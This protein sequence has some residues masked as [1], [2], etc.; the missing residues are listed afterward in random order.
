MS[1]PVTWQVILKNTTILSDC[2][3]WHHNLYT[4]IRF[5]QCFSY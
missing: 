3:Y 1:K 4:I 2:I 5:N